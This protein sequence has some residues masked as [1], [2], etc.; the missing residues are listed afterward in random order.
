MA[1]MKN[2]EL[3][4]ALLTGDRDEQ[5]KAREQLEAMSPEE[6]REF[7][8]FWNAALS[9]DDDDAEKKRDKIKATALRLHM[10]Q[11]LAPS[12]RMRGRLLPDERSL[13]ANVHRF[14]APSRADVVRATVRGSVL[15]MPMHPPTPAQARARIEELEAELEAH[16]AEFRQ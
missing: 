6:R 13:L 12:P 10:M 5:R 7:S 4:V 3:A 11:G 8:K 16:R 1:K 15:E 2:A 9:L 14:D